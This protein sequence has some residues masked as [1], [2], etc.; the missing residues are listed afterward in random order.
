ML[1]R[2]LVPELRSVER[3]LE[4]AQRRAASSRAIVREHSERAARQTSAAIRSP[5]TLALAAVAG[6]AGGRVGSTSRRLR[7]LEDQLATIERL[8]RQ[9]PESVTARAQSRGDGESDDGL[10]LQ[11]LLANVTRLAT[12]VSLITSSQSGSAP[13]EASTPEGVAAAAGD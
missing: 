12:L 6:F 13:E 1:L 7:A 10:D 5:V 4:L 2:L 11:A 3:R 8:V 9:T